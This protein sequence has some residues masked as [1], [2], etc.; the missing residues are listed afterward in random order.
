MLSF[1]AI[2]GTQVQ[3]KSTLSDDS[4]VPENHAMLLLLKAA[5]QLLQDAVPA[6][7]IKMEEMTAPATTLYVCLIENKDGET[8]GKTVATEG[9]IRKHVQTVHEG[10]SYPCQVPGC[11]KTYNSASNRKRHR[12]SEHEGVRYTCQALKCTKDFSDPSTAKKHYINCTLK[13]GT[14]R[15]S[16]K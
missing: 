4:S 11:D 9:G 10:V 16:E 7:H 14:Y 13:N 12:L 2:N 15:E 6:S 1:T 5:E 8:C 3:T